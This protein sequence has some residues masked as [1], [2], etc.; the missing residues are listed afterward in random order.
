MAQRTS[1]GAY[2]FARFE[3]AQAAPQ[4]VPARPQKTPRRLT[5]VPEPRKTRSSASAKIST[6][7]AER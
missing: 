1:G 4:R 2:D 3:R 5:K 6:P 7:C